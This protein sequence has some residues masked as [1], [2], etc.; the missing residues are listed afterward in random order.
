MRLL[1][2]IHKLESYRWKHPSTMSLTWQCIGYC[3]M[4]LKDHLMLISSEE[5]E[6]EEV[7]MSQ[8]SS[9]A[10]EVALEEE[11]DLKVK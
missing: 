4:Y 9:V 2:Y 7:G 3:N 5:P 10:E 8:V 1:T 11:V 6:E